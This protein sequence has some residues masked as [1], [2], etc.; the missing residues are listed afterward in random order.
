MVEVDRRLP[1]G[2]RLLHAGQGRLRALPDREDA[3]VDPFLV[4]E[5][6]HR[7]APEDVVHQARSQPDL[8]IVGDPRR[9]EAHVGEHVHEG[10]ER[11][12]VLEAV[13]HRDGEG[14]HDPGQRRALLGHL[15][16]DLAGPPVLELAD[17]H[18]AV[19][20]GHPERE[21]LG[22]APPGQLLADG[23]LE[24]DRLDDPLD[25]GLDRSGGG[26]A[27]LDR[28]RLAHLA[29]VAV[30]GDGLEAHAPRLDVEVLH[31]FHRGLLGHVDRVVVHDPVAH[32]GVRHRHRQVV[33]L[34]LAGGGDPLDGAE[35]EAVGH[36]GG[37]PVG[38]RHAGQRGH[39]VE[40]RPGH[41]TELGV[42]QE[43]ELLALFGG[44]QQVQLPGRQV[45]HE[46]AG[47]ARQVSPGEHVRRLGHD[48]RIGRGHQ[49][50]EVAGG[51][52]TDG[53]LGVEPAVHHTQV[54]ED[55]LQ[56]VE[57]RRRPEPDADRGRPGGAGHRERWPAAPAGRPGPCH[58]ARRS[59]A[60]GIRRNAAFSLPA[61]NSRK[62]DRRLRGHGHL[63]AT[64]VSAD[65]AGLEAEQAPPGAAETVE[66]R[67]RRVA[68]RHRGRRLRDPA[69]GGEGPEQEGELGAH[70]RGYLPGVGHLARLESGERGRQQR[71]QLGAVAQRH[72][73]AFLDLVET[74]P[75]E[76]VLPG[77]EQPVVGRADHLVA[78]AQH[79]LPHR[80]DTAVVEGVGLAHP[81]ER[82]DLDDLVA[83]AVG[84]LAVVQA[85]DADEPVAGRDQRL[86]HHALADGAGDERLDRRHHLHVPHVVDGV[87]AHGAGEHRQVR[88]PA[89]PARRGSSC[90]RRCRRRSRRPARPSTRAAAAP[91]GTVWLTM[92]I[93]PPPTS[94][95][96]LVSARSGSM[97]VVS[98]S[99]IRPM[100][101]WLTNPL[102]T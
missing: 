28:Q 46:V 12:A 8:G 97:P 76:P 27:L 24:H 1:G 26:G 49:V 43:G 45:R 34:T 101:L 7:Q 81:V 86:P 75:D 93:V 37:Q 22:V 88:R 38:Q 19:A 20:V 13:R 44:H 69:G 32:E 35:V 29:V 83:E 57:Q 47:T 74:P 31:V 79:D 41:V 59:T 21:R 4:G 56:V 36:H 96:A 85:A 14:V 92:N 25:L 30:D 63:R 16:E 95:L 33:D 11:H 84:L 72:R 39:G 60:A 77:H 2:G 73:L 67:L 70:L 68:D 10:L 87:V 53:D 40:R 65:D 71:P 94:F 5:V 99:I 62:A 23:L 17:D 58:A 82:G 3:H 89:G 50:E 6:L 91:A 61:T 80:P 90:A 52:A 66:H 64:P 18:V 98:Q 55:R 42:A 51:V 54:G 102:A 15:E 48:L 78:R 100:V 9:L